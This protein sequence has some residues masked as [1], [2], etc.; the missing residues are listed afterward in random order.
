MKPGAVHSHTWE[1]RFVELPIVSSS[2]LLLVPKAIVRKR[3]EYNPE[4]YYNN[5]I[6]EALQ[7]IEL[8]ANSELVELLRNG[9]RRVTKA[10]LREKYGT[11]KAVIVQLTR[12]HPEVLDRYR[13]AKRANPARP[14]S[15]AA[16]VDGDS[17]QVA[18]WDA[19]LDAVLQI[20]P[21]ASGADTYHRAIEA[22]F[23]AL[24]YPSLVNPVRESRL[25]E[26]RKRIDIK[27]TNSAR[28]GFFWR[29]HTH[30]G[31]QAGFV[32]V[33]CKNYSEDVSN[34]ELDQIAGRF[35]PAR[36]KL[37]LLVFRNADDRATCI[38]RCKDAF[39]DDRGWILPIMDSDL[40]VL[41]EERKANG[42]SNTYQLLEDRFAE[43]IS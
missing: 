20:S 2:K 10:S 8:S 13:A 1:N 40:R 26:G 15:N 18:N 42:F 3:L 14:M 9:N 39:H 34:P 28:D 33:E 30:H 32:V 4:D 6:L 31:V 36:G 23:Q 19:L 12:E 37:G 25:H 43:I 29:V 5:F 27:F 21:G 24:F 11:G 35:S 7:R 17:T 41:V 38:E 16:L 22:L